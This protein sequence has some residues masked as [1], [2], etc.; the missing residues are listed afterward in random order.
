M[1]VLALLV[2]IG[3][4]AVAVVTCAAVVELFR[5]LE[6]VRQLSGYVDTPGEVELPSAVGRSLPALGFPDTWADHEGLVVVLSPTCAMCYALGEHLARDP[7]DAARVLFTNGSRRDLDR[8]CAETGLAPDGVLFDDGGRV[9]DTLGLR[10]SPAA[11][12]VEGGLLTRAA[13]VPSPRAL[14]S[15]LPTGRPTRDGSARAPSTRS[16]S[17]DR[18]RVTR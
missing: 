2:S 15:L 4:L 10:L 16:P 13:S 17:A 18:R 8:F 5:D 14:R 1:S 11:L 7:E 6:Q 12:V 3:A 9:A